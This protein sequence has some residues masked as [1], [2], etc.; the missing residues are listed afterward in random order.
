MSHP[1]HSATGGGLL[2]FLQYLKNKGLMNP[3]TADAQAIAVGKV[4]EIEGDDWENASLRDINIDEL[5]VRFETL[6]G[7]NYTP[8]SLTTYKSRFAKAVEMYLDYLESPS[9]FKAPATRRARRSSS[10]QKAKP[11]PKPTMAPDSLPTV[12]VDEP[13]S[14]LDL[15]EYPFPLSTGT[16]A[17]LRLPRHI[18]DSDVQRLASFIRS[19]A[20]QDP[21][22]LSKASNTEEKGGDS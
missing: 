21:G 5:L 22:L 15:I 20:V 6:R 16:M 1:I 8:S 17:Y 11:A 2:A 7:S 18:P 14:R 19:V 4:L 12:T 13:T 10:A 3:S 9:A